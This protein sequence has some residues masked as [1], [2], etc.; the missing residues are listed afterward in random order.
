MVNRL[1]HKLLR[2]LQMWRHLGTGW[3][4]FRLSYAI[5]TRLGVIRRRTP[6]AAWDDQPLASF[7]K[8]PELADPQKYLAY[9]L[10]QAPRFFF[11]P[12]DRGPYHGQLIR[13]H[14]E[15]SGPVSV[16][17]AVA[18][19]TFC[20]FEHAR[21]D[22]GFPPDWHRNAF[23]GQRVPPDRH[24]SEVSSFG[25]G[26]VKIIW[27]PNRFGFV[28]DL[29]R[30]YWR[31]GDEQYAQVFWQLVEG[32]RDENPPQQGANWMCG[33]EVSLRVMAWCF[34]LYGFLRSEATTADRVGRLAEMIAVCGQRVAANISYALSQKNNHGISEGMGLWTI[35]LLFPEFRQ[36][37]KWRATGRRV[38]ERLGR[39]LIYD[40]G[41]F[42]QHSVNYQRLMLQLYLW[43][44]QLGELNDQP[45]SEELRERVG[46]SAE[47]LYQLQDE[48][49]GYLPNAGS[50]DGAHILPLANCD[51]RDYRPVIQAL[52]LLTKQARCYEPGAWDEE[53][54]WLLGPM[55]LESPTEPPQKR[56]LRAE[57]DGHYTLR[58][59]QGFAYMRCTTFRHRPGHADQLHVDLWWRGQNMALDPGTYSYNAPPLWDN[60]LQGT[61]YHNT[62]LV[63]GKDQADRAGRFLWLPW[64]RGQAQE[65]RYSQK[66]LLAYWEGAHD[67]YKR[68]RPPVLHR[69]GVLRIGDEQWVIL[70]ALISEGSHRY[71]LHWLLADMPH[72]WDE[73]RGM[74]AMDTP[75]GPYYAQ[76]GAIEGSGAYSLVRAD[77]HSARGWWSQYYFSREPA[78]SIAMEL[79]A[80]TTVLW[81]VMGP[82]EC[83]AQGKT[84][85][86]ALVTSSW[87]ATIGL[88]GLGG[89]ES[90]VEAVS[91]EGAI[92]DSLTPSS[93]IEVRV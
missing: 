86:L 32:W 50:N 31:T 4:A 3:L 53:A 21:V 14:G 74:V 27:E 19:G 72:Q 55:A 70:D 34:G 16:A 65:T 66:G 26:D 6:L 15:D 51:Y 82:E 45:L 63:D 35:G 49:T 37:E 71:R 8:D 18:E 89:W 41:G 29:V 92:E 57:V 20:Y 44:M 79:E 46:R 90:L 38:L 25:Q 62:V 52:W 2:L 13:Y 67:G 91:V 28:Y 64:P 83:E 80:D 9:R 88:T 56:N 85:Q 59:R 75:E 10:E 36:A 76:M 33:Q 11:D 78:V 40:D 39:E 47:L 73:A 22:L 43:C 1:L 54:L 24:W 30:A 87:R 93:R 12:S 60:Q 81:T 7:L 23:T 84:G 77:E 42:S 17:D 58:S 5:S 61:A 48:K 69:R 68:L